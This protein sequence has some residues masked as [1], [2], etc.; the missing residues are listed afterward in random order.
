MYHLPRALNRATLSL[1]SILSVTS[2]AMS[3]AYAVEQGG[4]IAPMGVTDFG[5]GMLPPPSPHGMVGVRAS[6]YSS[7]TVKD[8]SGNTIPND[9]NLDVKTL[10]LAY[11]YM[12]EL[13]LFGA[14]V[15][16]GGILPLIDIDGS[17]NVMTPGGALSIAGD[18]FGLGDA[19]I[20]P[21]MLGWQAPPNLFVN[22]GLQVQMPT[23]DYDVSNAFNAGVNHWTITPFLGAT[24]IT[25]SG[26]EVST[27]ATLNFNT[28]NPDTDYTSGVEY[29]QEFAAGQHFGAWTAGVAGYAYQQITDDKGPGSGD[30]NRALGPAINFFQPGLPMVSL[31]A[32]KEFGAE[33]RAEGYNVALRLGMSF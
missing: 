5:A 10:A 4:T 21:I 19:Q 16:F 3:P 7:S 9:F 23:G 14:S 1:A 32:Y 22:A 29:R 31:H 15:G 28:V 30:G 11:F 24:Y 8:G 26:F 33:N 27:Q 2:L 13:E 20:V 18:D 25:D 17:L 6:Y 12:T